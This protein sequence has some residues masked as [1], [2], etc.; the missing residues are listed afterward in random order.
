MGF[1]ASGSAAIIF[2]GLGVAAGLTLPPIIGSFGSL[3]SAQDDQA[4]RAVNA[5]N[6]EF[7][8]A[9]AEYAAGTEELTLTLE[10]TGS[11]TPTAS[12]TT[13]LVDGLALSPPDITTA[14]DGDESAT[15][16]LPNQTLTITA[17]AVSE[18]PE[19]VKIIAENGIAEAAHGDEIEE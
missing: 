7:N 9:E 1:S 10:N 18:P 6:T 11:T 14:V 16:W 13:T 4:D 15:L 2:V 17:E 3:A 12:R 19:Q 8:I 5:L